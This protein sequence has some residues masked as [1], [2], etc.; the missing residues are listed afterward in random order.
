MVSASHELETD[1]EGITG[2]TVDVP[3]ELPSY[4]SPSPP[5]PPVIPPIPEM[6]VPNCVG[7]RMISTDVG[8]FATNAI[9]DAS[10][11][12]YAVNDGL[13]TAD[14]LHVYDIKRDPFHWWTTGGVERTLWALSLS[15]IWKLEDFPHGTWTQ[16]VTGAAIRAAIGAVDGPQWGRMDFSIEVEDRYAIAAHYGRG[17]S[18]NV[19]YGAH[20]I[21][22]GAIQSSVVGWDPVHPAGT[23]IW[24]DIKFAQ[25][26]A[27]TKLLWCRSYN[28]GSGFVYLYRTTDFG[29]NWVI[30]VR[31]NWGVYLNLSWP[32]VDA[33][34][35][36]DLYAYWNKD[37]TSYATVDGGMTWTLPGW[38]SGNRMGTGGNQDRIFV[39]KSTPTYSTDGGGSWTSLPAHGLGRVVAGLVEWGLE[40]PECVLLGDEDG[41]TV[42][43]WQRGMTSYLDKTGNLADFGITKIYS[44]D[45]DTMGGA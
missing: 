6:P 45:R 31:T 1:D 36:D 40:G 7:R 5:P 25:H 3:G 27:G 29:D 15:G 23:N 35:T 18:N 14:D 2:A 22:A 8:V 16:I 30:E 21:Q 28:A 4:P 42:S 38:N 37:G 41:D 33:G 26:S 9:G 10:P 39:I 13:T 12:W 11:I 44:I 17:G 34:N 19:G 32:Y 24:S 20:T 43:Y